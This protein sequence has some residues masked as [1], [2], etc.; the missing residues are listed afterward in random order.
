MHDDLD[1][2]YFALFDLEPRFALVINRLDAAYRALA[3]RVHP[4]RFARGSDA[5]RRQSLML[6][7]YANEAY[8]VLKNPVLRARHLLGLR[9][10]ET[11][12]KGTVLP[13]EFLA[14]QMEWREALADAKAA[15]DLAALERIESIIK[16]RSASMQEQLAQQLDH[17][18]DYAGAAETM[19]KLMFLEKLIGEIADAR[20]LLTAPD[21]LSP[22]APAR[23]CATED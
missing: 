23:P 12:E 22:A 3:A 21:I 4:D 9:G 18:H 5:E 15:C 2:G 1:H 8:R 11:T 14:E 7:T 19:H 6:A 13:C 17:E 20:A 10:V 16:H